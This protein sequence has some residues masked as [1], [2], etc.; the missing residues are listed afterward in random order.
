MNPAQQPQ[1]NALP[2]HTL[3]MY[4]L[5]QDS[6]ETHWTK[7]WIDSRVNVLPKSS[8]GMDELERV[9]TNLF[10]TLRAQTVH[11]LHWAY[12]RDA[13]GAAFEK[14]KRLDGDSDRCGLA[15]YFHFV[16]RRA[17][18]E[19]S[20]LDPANVL[21]N[22]L[23]LSGHVDDIAEDRDGHLA[24]NSDAS[25]FIQAR[26]LEDFETRW[27]AE[28]RSLSLPIIDAI[29]DTC[30]LL[31]A[32]SDPES[33]MPAETTW[34]DLRG[35]VRKPLHRHRYHTFSCLLSE[36]NSTGCSPPSQPQIENVRS[37][38]ASGTSTASVV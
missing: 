17:R 25:S 38:I 34:R 31:G 15:A 12:N 32:A 6:S 8:A 9:L 19:G 36:E 27:T 13:R 26:T 1:A 14:L 10:A 37:L 30:T 29:R 7:P 33:S 20:V 18:A 16:Y 4:L 28:Q 2:D 23:R 5:A 35:A 22:Y 11:G 3:L 24:H 21:D